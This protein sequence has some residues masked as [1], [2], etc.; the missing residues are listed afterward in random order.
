M[1]S[2]SSRVPT[3]R[4][5]SARRSRV[6]GAVLALAC[7]AQ[8]ASGSPLLSSALALGLHVHG[9]AH[10]VSM[11]LDDGHVDLVLSHPHA[12]AAADH[13]TE[14]GL[15]AWDAGHTDHVVH[16]SAGDSAHPRREA[17]VQAALAGWSQASVAPPSP[18]IRREATAPCAVAGADRRPFVLRL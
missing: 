13:A 15:V 16:V 2:M 9:H 14:P 10:A 6:L 11:V 17:P 3:R 1:A 5:A 8:P 4:S 7:A 18:S 12:D